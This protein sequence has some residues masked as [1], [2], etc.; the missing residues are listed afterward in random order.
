MLDG[1]DSLVSSARPLVDSVDA[2]VQVAG[3]ARTNATT[4]F[5]R[6][7]RTQRSGEVHSYQVIPD[8]LGERSTSAPAV[9]GQRRNGARS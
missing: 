3:L 8:H 6:A 1:L 4:T 2:S 9:Q 5:N 7:S